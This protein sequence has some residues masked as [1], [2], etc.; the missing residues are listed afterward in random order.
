MV[1]DSMLSF[2]S[3]L[4]VKDRKNFKVNYNFKSLRRKISLKNSVYDVEKNNFSLVNNKIAKISLKT[5]NKNVGEYLPILIKH[6]I[7]D[8]YIKKY[9]IDNLYLIKN[10]EEY[11]RLT[12]VFL[13]MFN[14]KYGN[15]YNFEIDVNH[16]TV[17]SVIKY[18]ENKLN[19]VEKYKSEKIDNIFDD[20]LF[21]TL[22]R[23]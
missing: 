7:F 19:D 3:L 21:H 20:E 5:T 2:N 1:K 9:K 18:N 16:D 17:F 6:T 10:V 23:L 8:F 15:V 14:Q 12:K 22:R 4:I 11:Y 13:N